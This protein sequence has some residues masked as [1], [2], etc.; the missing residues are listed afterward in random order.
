MNKDKLQAFIAGRIR[1]LRQQRGLSQEKLSE[2]AGLGT[3][4]IHNIEKQKYNFQIQTLSKIISALDVDEATFFNF[5]FPNQSQEVDNL[6]EQ[7]LAL[8]DAQRDSIVEAINTLLRN[9]NNQ[10]R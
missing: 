6:I 1:Y 3:K 4:H 8:P 9:I 5:D 2:L 10:N 7:L